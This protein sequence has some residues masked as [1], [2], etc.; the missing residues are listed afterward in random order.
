MKHQTKTSV[1]RRPRAFSR[2]AYVGFRL[3]E[4]DKKRLWEVARKKV[5]DPSSFLVEWTREGIARLEQELIGQAA[6]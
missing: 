4:D 3:P 1:Q 2:A 5:R 6:R